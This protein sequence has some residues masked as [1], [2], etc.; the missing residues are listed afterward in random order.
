MKEHASDKA[1]TARLLLVQDERLQRWKGG[2][3]SS[4]KAAA[5]AVAERPG[6]GSSLLR[7]VLV[8]VLWA[9]AGGQL[10]WPSGTGRN[11]RRWGQRRLDVGNAALSG[12]LRRAELDAVE[13]Y[14]VAVTGAMEHVVEHAASVTQGSRPGRK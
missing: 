2:A 6:G 4:R 14:V 12:V 9:R 5:R 3:R 10:G 11:P 13:L 7:T 1:G 8:V